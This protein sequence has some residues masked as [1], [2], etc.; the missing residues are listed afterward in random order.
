MNQ[1]FSKCMITIPALKKILHREVELLPLFDRG[2]FRFDC[3]TVFVILSDSQGCF[4]LS[5]KMKFP[6]NS[7][8]VSLKVPRKDDSLE[9]M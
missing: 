4:E 3:Y 7:V 1:F 2:S 9:A 5:G 8:F 6:L